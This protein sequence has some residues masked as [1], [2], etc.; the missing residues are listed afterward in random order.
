MKFLDIQETPVFTLDQ[1]KKGPGSYNVHD[2]IDDNLLTYGS[3]EIGR[4][5]SLCLRP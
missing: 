5:L 4:P 1:R 3:W 2:F